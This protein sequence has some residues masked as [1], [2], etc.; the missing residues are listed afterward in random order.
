[1]LLQVP[2]S[3]V[4]HLFHLRNLP[5]SP[6]LTYQWTSWKY[7]QLRLL[8]LL[9]RPVPTSAALPPVLPLPNKLWPTP[10]FYLATSHSHGQAFAFGKHHNAP[11]WCTMLEERWRGPVVPLF[12]RVRMFVGIVLSAQYGKS[13]RHSSFSEASSLWYCC[14]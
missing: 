9:R 3:T 11:L 12:H 2:C 7:D 4:E 10:H 13:R 5:K 6:S 8:T 14:W 1:M